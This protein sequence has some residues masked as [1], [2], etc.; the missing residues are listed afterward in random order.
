MDGSRFDSIARGF[1]DRRSRRGALK[2]LLGG[3]VGGAAAIAGLDGVEAKGKPDCCPSNAPTLCGLTCTPTESDPQNCGACGHVCGANQV[4]SNGACACAHG[5]TKCG[6]ACIVAGSAC[7]TGKAGPCAAGT[8][9][10]VNNAPVCKQTVQPKPET[11]NG[12]DDDCD[13]VIDNGA[14]CPAG[15]TCTGG[16]CVTVKKGNGQ[17][18]A[19]GTECTSGFCA[20]G[21]CCD[22]A[23]AGTCEACNVAGSVG[24]CAAVTGTPAAG[25]GTCPGDSSV[26]GRAACDGVNRAACTYPSAATVCSAASCTNGVATDAGHCDGAGHCTAGAQ[27]SCNTYLCN[28]NVCGTTCNG[29]PQ[30]APGAYCSGG[31]C[32][33][34]L[35]AGSI[36]ATNSQ[37]LSGVCLGNHCCTAACSASGCQ[38]ACDATGACVNAAT[39]S[40]CAGG[41]CNGAG[42]C[43][44]CVQ[45]SDCPGTN[46]D[47]QQHVCQS[48]SCV[49]QFTPAGTLTSNQIPGDCHKNVCDGSGNII[50]Q[51]DDT[52]VPVDNNP[53][54]NDV[55]TNGVASN[56]PAAQGTSCGVNGVCD[57]GGT[58]TQLLAAGSS[59]TQSQQC[60]SSACLGGHC[61]AAVCNQ[62]GDICA[63]A[64]GCDASGT[65][66]LPPTTTA[67]TG[68]FCNGIG[69]CVQCNTAADCGSAN[70]GTVACIGNICR[71]TLCSGGFADCNGQFSD[72]CEVNIAN[73][74]NNCGACGHQCSAPNGIPGCSAGTCSVVACNPGY[75]DC[76]GIVSDGCETFVGNDVNNCG[77]CG[78]KCTGG[79]SCTNSVCQ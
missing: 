34:D 26:C 35:P 44:A 32:V 67:C 21:V 63:R 57:G 75:E 64:V 74:V 59:C 78:N 42:S 66:L 40:P 28:G 77:S 54:T 7:S 5:T 49:S 36:C 22:G 30:C 27:H 69:D 3:A 18:C 41:I 2:A 15:Q 19:S 24:T 60:A 62:T 56:P 43:V 73:D 20:D 45:N 53:C 11:C 55:C 51:I 37:C 9:A 65:C 8:L 70:N 10:C 38:N 14:T 12:I 33:Q 23:C 71:L 17:S 68:G 72:G 46:T 6:T 25:H 39:G 76:N 61:C 48:N 13:G 31:N 1:A 29:D 47:C 58:C 50:S 79:K 16:Q 52:D 4:C